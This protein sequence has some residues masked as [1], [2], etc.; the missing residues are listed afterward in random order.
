MAYHTNRAVD[1]VAMQASDVTLPDDELDAAIAAEAATRGNV[2]NTLNNLITLIEVQVSAAHDSAG[3]HKT[4]SIATAALQ[5]GAVTAPKLSTNIVTTPNIVWDS[6]NLVAPGVNFDGRSQWFNPDALSQLAPDTDNKYGLPTTVFTPTGPIPTAGK[7]VWLDRARVKTGDTLQFGI[8]GLAP[9]SNSYRALAR[10]YTAA[11]VAVGAQIA[12]PI[13]TENGTE[14]D[15]QVTGCVVPATAAYVALF[16]ARTAGA[17]PFKIFTWRGTQGEFL[18]AAATPQPGDPSLTARQS[19]TNLMFDATWKWTTPGTNWGGRTRWVN[20]TALSILTPDAQNPIDA[21]NGRTLQFSTV[22]TLAGVILWLDE[23]GISAAGDAL[24]GTAMVRAASGKMALAC[25]YIDNAGVNLAVQYAGATVA[26]DGTPQWLTFANAPVPTGAVAVKVYVIR[27]G[28]SATISIYEMATA[29][30]PVGTIGLPSGVPSW[31]LQEIVDGR[32]SY[33]TL[34]ARISASLGAFPT[35]VDRY[36][37]YL[38]R[39]THAQISKMRRA[40]AGQ[41][42][43]IGAIGDSWVNNGRIFNALRTALQAKYGN[44]G[45]GW[46]SADTNMAVPPGGGRTVSGTWTLRDNTDTPVGYGPDIGSAY[47]SEVGAMMTFA[48]NQTDG[49]L[50]YL[51]QPGGGS[52][53][54]SVD[55]TSWTTEATANATLDAGIITMPTQAVASRTLTVRVKTAGTAGVEILGSSSRIAGINGVLLHQFGNGG[56]TAL[57]Y[58]T[59]NAT[60]TQGVLAALELNL[61][62]YVLAT[63][64]DA[65]EVVLDD[66]ATAMTTLVGRS[67]TAR[68]ACDVFLL[69]PSANNDTNSET[70]AHSMADYRTKLRDIAVA[71]DTACLDLYSHMP[72]WTAANARGMYNDDYHLSDAGGRFAAD[73]IFAMIDG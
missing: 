28:G 29:S 36:G 48:S 70:T 37:A 71:Q 23:I 20:D 39:D 64:D 4:N 41:Q 31:A 56:A 3:V 17:D 49:K 21:T 9:T 12:G 22:T 18:P 16:L 73:Q 69:I 51:K 47:S 72:D 10:F 38:L 50:F 43:A 24:S 2:D 59:G 53:E 7:K 40:E 54:W 27:I 19:A 42:L 63:N 57:Q 46:I 5:T 61:V 1:G 8:T 11:G 58:A 45:V 60:V 44:A 62:I 14:Q 68:T 65:Q 30:V 26:A 66:F 52:F 32:G 67:R 55:G 25:R 15:H 34:N 33:A 13:V 6:H 35:S